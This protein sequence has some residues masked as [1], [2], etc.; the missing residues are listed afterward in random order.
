MT[1]SF[2]VA[3]T[4]GR[5]QSTASRGLGGSTLVPLAAQLS[6]NSYTEHSYGRDARRKSDP[7]ERHD[8][9][10]FAAPFLFPSYAAAAQCPV[11]D[12]VALTSNLDCNVGRPRCTYQGGMKSP[13]SNL[14]SSEC[15][16]MDMDEPWS[17][18]YWARH[19]Q[20]GEHELVRIVQAVGPDSEAVGRFIREQSK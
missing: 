9:G 16:A 19:F 6:A 18:E 14:T 8:E 13:S 17:R 11:G 3:P 1:P 7:E 15:H 5:A 2:E 10:A 4:I 12:I 20:V